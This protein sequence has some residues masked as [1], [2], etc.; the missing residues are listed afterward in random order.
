MKKTLILFFLIS[1]LSNSLFAKAPKHECDRLA[2]HPDDPFKVI[3]ATDWDDLI[4][5]KAIIACTEAIKE[6]PNETRFLFQLG[7]AETK[8][9]QKKLVLFC[10]EWVT[11]HFMI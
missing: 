4:S 10:R 3:T 7:R 8:M 1:I 6:Y 11:L 2:A 5:D 9:L